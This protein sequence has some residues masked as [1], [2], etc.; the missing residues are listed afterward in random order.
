[1]TETKFMSSMSSMAR[2]AATEARDAAQDVGKAAAAASGD[3]RDDL[4]ALRDDVTRLAQQIAGIVKTGGGA[5]WRKAQDSGAEA[6][7]AVRE[8]GDNMVGA[9]DDSLHK[10]PYTTLALALGIG[11]LIGTAS[12]RR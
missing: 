2:D 5:T 6:V 9:L 4:S 8:I 10:R 11:F 7:D 3:I 1:M 12:W